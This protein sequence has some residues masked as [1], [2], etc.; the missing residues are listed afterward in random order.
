MGIPSTPATR[1]A[2]TVE[3]LN[4]F[5]KDSKTI[6]ARDGYNHLDDVLARQFG[7]LKYIDVYGNRRQDE[8]LA[9]KFAQ[10]LF[11]LLTPGNYEINAR[12][13]RFCRDHGIV[14]A[15]NEGVNEQGGALVPMEF[16]KMIVRLVER[17]G[18][19]RKYAR[20]RLMTGDVRTM[21]RRTSG[22]TANWVVEGAT[23]TTSEPTYDNLSMVAKK[24]ATLTTVTS[25]INEDTAI[26]IA[27][28]VAAE[29]AQAYA[30]A[31]DQA[32]FNG[33]GS[34]SFGGIIGI[35]T[36]LKALSATIADIAGLKVAAGNT[37]AEFVLQDFLDTMG[38]LPSYADQFAGWFCHRS[39]FFGTMLRCALVGATNLAVGGV[40]S[41]GA[42]GRPLFLGY[43][44]NFT[45]VMPRTD[46]NSSLAALFGSLE[47]AAILGD[48]RNRTLFVDPYS[49]AT[50]DQI[51]VRAIERVDLVTHS[52]GNASST[53][54]LRVAGPVV[55]LISAAS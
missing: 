46:S 31:E 37:F 13:R 27:D 12:A 24:L 5:L 34:P 2:E 55:G 41:M 14:K 40:V 35:T 43:P 48:R 28:E 19:F 23:I 9:F 32:G 29:V 21:A 3:A 33:D 22:L 4:Q 17:F 25:E 16:D 20:Q 26:S 49:L 30:E 45:Q 54:S 52:V 18:T 51:R 38:L 39:F 10:W 50:S 11:V 7:S 42:D 36:K 8:E 15:L 47:L 44:V 53:P 1:Q 6:A